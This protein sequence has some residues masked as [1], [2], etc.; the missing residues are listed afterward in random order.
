[1]EEDLIILKTEENIELETEEVVKSE[2]NAE[3]MEQSIETEESVEAV[4]VKTVEEIEIEVDE[5]VGWVG[6]D[7][8]RHYSLYGRDEADQ[9][10]IGAI[11]GLRTELDQIEKLQIVY[12]KAV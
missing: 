11:T 5:A 7:S 8:T 2:V 3:D 10:P 12:S 1:M 6:G 9:H 4:E